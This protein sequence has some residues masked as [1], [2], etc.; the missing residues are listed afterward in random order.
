MHASLR[1]CLF[2]TGAGLICSLGGVTHL[3]AQ[4]VRAP[5]FVFEP[6]AITI[7]AVSAPLQTGSSTG[8]NL[9]FLALFPTS[10]PWLTLELGTSLAPLGLSNGRRAFNSPTFHYG[11][12]VML[13]PRDRSAEWVEITV[14]VLGSY[15]L[16][17]SGDADRIYVNDLVV[18]TALAVPLG[19]KLMADM[20]SFWS[21]LTLYGVVEQNLTPGR[22]FA[23][24]RVDRLNPT[25]LYGVSIPIR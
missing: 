17:E 14:P 24:R 2:L 7:N 3:E 1:H 20:G 11:G 8:V 15:H 16:D 22:N 18:Q 5:T 12:R 23:T 21:T 9:R 13:L 4:R 19:G 25:F 10:I 6:G